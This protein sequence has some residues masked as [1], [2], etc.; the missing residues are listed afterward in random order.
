MIER[1][2][3]NW[4]IAWQL[5]R[6]LKRVSSPLPSSSTSRH[7]EL[8]K[9]QF[10]TQFTRISTGNLHFEHQ[11]YF[12][13]FVLFAYH[14]SQGTTPQNSQ[15]TTPATFT[16]F[17]VFKF[18]VHRFT[19]NNLAGRLPR[20]IAT[21]HNKNQN[22]TRTLPWAFSFFLVCYFF[23][24]CNFCTYSTTQPE[25][26]HGWLSHSHAMFLGFGHITQHDQFHARCATERESQGT[27]LPRYNNLPYLNSYFTISAKIF[28]T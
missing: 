23:T 10:E 17:F 26:S 25:R 1:T 6:C 11:I 5:Y 7:D 16:L 14:W 4:T 15:G 20:S 28:P 3:L 19:E 2:K 13:G 21:A 27:T 12:F 24:F 9:I 8:Q 18:I 22:F